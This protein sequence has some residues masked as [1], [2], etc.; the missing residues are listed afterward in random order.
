MS[1]EEHLDIDPCDKDEPGESKA[2][3]KAAKKAADG[4]VAVQAAPSQKEIDA[5][6]ARMTTDDKDRVF[7]ALGGN[8]AKKRAPKG[9]HK[10][11]CDDA[12][13]NIKP[14]IKYIEDNH[15]D[16]HLELY[17]LGLYVKDFE[18]RLPEGDDHDGCKKWLTDNKESI[19]L[20]KQTRKSTTATVPSS[21]LGKLTINEAEAEGAGAD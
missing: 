11:K 3:A 6:V 5:F 9:T 15:K 10:T 21:P 12:L 17:L 19:G 13:K 14:T 1:D 7:V 2:A 18:N 16:E 20:K 8:S 4:K